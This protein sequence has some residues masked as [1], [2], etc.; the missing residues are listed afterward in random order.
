MI[1]NIFAIKF[2]INNKST[3]W[4]V[5]WPGRQPVSNPETTAILAR[6]AFE[7]RAFEISL[8]DQH[9]RLYVSDTIAESSIAALET[10]ATSHIVDVESVGFPTEEDAIN[11][12]DIAEKH[13]VWR[14]LSK[15]HNSYI[16]DIV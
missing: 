5:Y 8:C 6:L 11:F 9:K 1:T 15:N 14:N 13:I 7:T 12:I 4:E 16:G 10:L 2:N 3:P